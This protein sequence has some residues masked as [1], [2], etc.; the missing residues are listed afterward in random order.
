MKPKLLKLIL[1]RF[2]GDVTKFCSFW[3]S[4]KSAVD[5]NDELSVVDKFNYLQSLLERPAAKLIQIG[6]PNY[7]QANQVL[8]G[9]FGNR[10]YLLIWMIF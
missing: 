2:S 3:D 1:P 9:C 8:E 5:E 6:A 10:S 4:L 7:E